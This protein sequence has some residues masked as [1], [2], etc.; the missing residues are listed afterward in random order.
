MTPLLDVRNLSTV[1]H[2]PSGDVHAVNNIS[3]SLEAG[4]SLA[5]VGES[6]SGK[7]V[8][9]LS[10][11]GLV[12]SPGKVENGQVEFRDCDIVN[13]PK[14]ELQ[15][16]RGRR[17]GMVFQDPMTSLN[18]VLSVGYQLTEALIWHMNLNKTDARKQVVETM[19]LVG[20][21]NAEERLLDYPHQFSGGQRQRIMIAM[22]I[23]CRPDLL[24]ADEPTTALDVTIQAQ[25]VDLIKA[26]QE[27]F[28]MAV[29][30]ITHDLALVAGIVDRVAVMYAGSIVER[31]T[32]DAIFSRAAHP[33]TQCLL[34]SMPGQ[35]STARGRLYSIEGNPPD[36]RQL[37][38][39]CAFAARCPQSVERCLEKRPS[40]EPATSTNCV[41]CWQAT[42]P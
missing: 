28:G 24:I 15:R 32:V 16:L 31:G 29:I 11:I 8:S 18:P 27:K 38:D 10:I 35:E 4:E 40:L 5:I 17:I 33:Y 21:S 19:H 41:A 22:A 12:P 23:V 6:G 42:L 36:L 30:W 13:L 14:R 2:S 3:F 26:L 37:T 20:I 25:I 39:S 1:F 9:A 7:S 34:R